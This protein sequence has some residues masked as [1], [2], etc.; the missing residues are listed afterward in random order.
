MRLNEEQKLLVQLSALESGLQ[1]KLVRI[2]DSWAVVGHD[3]DQPKLWA[4]KLVSRVQG[5]KVWW[6]GGWFYDRQRKGVIAQLTK[7]V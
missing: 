7:E 6:A 4:G 5:S 1:G 2:G 3:Q